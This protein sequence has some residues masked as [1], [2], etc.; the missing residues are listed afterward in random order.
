MKRFYVVYAPPVPFPFDTKQQAE[1]QC[2]V[3]EAMLAQMRVSSGH[4]ILFKVL[5]VDT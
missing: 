3:F 2:K 1:A 5:E 4:R